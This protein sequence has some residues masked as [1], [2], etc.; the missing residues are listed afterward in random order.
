MSAAATTITRMDA[1]GVR[2]VDAAAPAPGPERD[3]HREQDD[4]GDTE[5]NP[6]ARQVGM[7]RHQQVDQRDE[8]RDQHVSAP[9]RQRNANP[10]ARPRRISGCGSEDRDDHERRQDQAVAV[11]PRQREHHGGEMA[12][13]KQVRRPRLPR[14]SRRHQRD[15]GQPAERREQQLRMG[16]I[17]ALKID[18][19]EAE[20]HL[21]AVPAHVVHRML[22]SDPRDARHIVDQT[23]RWRRRVATLLNQVGRETVVDERRPLP[24]REED[25]LA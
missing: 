5:R 9:P 8:K 11:D 15:R 23:H 24:L 19:A 17:S 6:A 2:S 7:P 13:G 14:A 3:D 10:H 20:D 21:A 16:A 1:H 12:D 22:G 25:R 18:E 4:F